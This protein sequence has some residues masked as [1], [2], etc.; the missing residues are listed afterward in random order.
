M[1]NIRRT[2]HK[3]ALV[4]A[5]S[6]SL[7]MLGG[8][9]H[10]ASAEDLNKDAAQALQTLYKTNPV[11]ENL[12]KTARGILVFPKIIKAG[13][14]FGG[15]YGEGVLTKGSQFAGYY[16]SVSASWGWQAGAESYGYVVFLMSDKAVKYLDK[17][18]GWEF[19]V[20]PSV[21]VVNEGMAK[22]LSSLTL[23]DDAYAFI[24]DQQGLMASLSIEGTKISRIKR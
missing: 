13:L 5:A 24:F 17:S 18:K 4:T 6:F 14:V 19:G 3:L 16:N 8:N 12:S 22:K 23:K 1:N 20:G 9:V 10:A 7:G 11:A 21:V 15:S 2:F